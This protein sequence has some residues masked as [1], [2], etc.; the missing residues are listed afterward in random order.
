MK[1]NEMCFKSIDD[2]LI[3]LKRR[4]LTKEMVSSRNRDDF[5]MTNVKVTFTPFKRKSH[6]FV[7]YTDDY[8]DYEYNRRS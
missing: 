2:T 7:G 3:G 1:K 8:E 6:R 4:K 5:N